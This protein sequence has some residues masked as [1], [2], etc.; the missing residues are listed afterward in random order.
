MTQAISA[1][2]IAD[3]K[4]ALIDAEAIHSVVKDD[5]DPTHLNKINKV[6][7]DLTEV[8]NSMEGLNSSDQL[9]R[10]LKEIIRLKLRIL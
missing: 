1:K 3:L 6:I 5:R 7:D 2:S 4:D 10:W 9:P 8:Q